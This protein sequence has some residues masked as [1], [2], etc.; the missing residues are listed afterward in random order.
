M[1]AK[2]TKRKCPRGQELV[3]VEAP[4]DT[5]DFEIYFFQKDDV[6][7][8]KVMVGPKTLFNIDK[9]KTMIKKIKIIFF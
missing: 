4:L 2:G 1:G 5:F 8:L 9:T 3:T 7:F 6:H